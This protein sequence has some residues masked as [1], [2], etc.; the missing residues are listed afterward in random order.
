MK[1]V[2]PLLLAAGIALGACAGGSGSQ[3]SMSNNDAQSAI[4]AAEHELDRAK[5]M[6]YAWR[7]TGKLIKKAK[8][9]MKDGDTAKAVKLANEAKTQSTLAIA[10]EKNQEGAG[11]DYSM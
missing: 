2:F 9:A 3:S 4:A 7:D 11:P 10:Q 6:N 8:A 5:S 1:K